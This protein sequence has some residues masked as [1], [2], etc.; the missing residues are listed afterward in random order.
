MARKTYVKN[1]LD[2]RNA[3]MNDTFVKTIDPQL[4]RIAL[5][6]IANHKLT[7]LEPQLPFAQHF[8]KIHQEDITGTHLDR[9]KMSTISILS[10]SL[11]NISMDIDELTIDD[12]RT[13]EQDIAKFLKI[14][15]NQAMKGN[16]KLPNKKVTSSIITGNQRP[17]PYRSQSNISKTRDFSRHRISNRHAFSISKQYYGTTNFKSP[18]RTGSPYPR[19]Q[20]I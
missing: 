13:M 15:F 1:A 4:A 18:S 3:Q 8:E 9:H 14:N 19:L 2:M 6:K 20:N 7:A 11:N 16:Q 10:S 12:I 5:K 17:F